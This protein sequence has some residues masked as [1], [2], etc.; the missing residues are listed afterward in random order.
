MPATSAY[1]TC[2]CQRENEWFEDE[3]VECGRAHYHP[4]D[5]ATDEARA[6]LAQVKASMARIEAALLPEQDDRPLRLPESEIPF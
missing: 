4:Y 6:I 2:K 3:C 5:R 1:W